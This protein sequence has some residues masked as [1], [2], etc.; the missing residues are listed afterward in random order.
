MHTVNLAQRRLPLLESN[1]DQQAGAA[2]LA[3]VPDAVGLAATFF[4]AWRATR[5]NPAALP[6]L[7]N[8]VSMPHINKVRLLSTEPEAS[9]WQRATF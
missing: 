1:L 2:T 8:Y 6:Y 7:L 5:G 4:P 3:A 9:Q